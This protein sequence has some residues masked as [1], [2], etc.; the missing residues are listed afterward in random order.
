MREM[1]GNQ[2]LLHF[3]HFS[4]IIQTAIILIDQNII[5]R[6]NKSQENYRKNV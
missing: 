1:L 6:L 4:E 3:L 2:I 5:Y